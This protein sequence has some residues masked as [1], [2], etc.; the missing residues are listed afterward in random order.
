MAIKTSILEDKCTA[1]EMLLCYAQEM[2]G[3][4]HTY[5]EDII[6]MVLPMLKFYLNDGVRYAAASVIPVLLQCWIKANYPKEKIDQLWSLICNSLMDAIV[7][8]EDLSLLCTF[9]N[10]LCDV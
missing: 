7:E 8:E 6:K 5:V 3:M 2:G 4:F 9:Y 10:T 1:V